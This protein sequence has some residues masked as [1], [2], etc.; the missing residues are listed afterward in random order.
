MSNLK[1][2]II[3]CGYMAQM[4]HIPCLKSNTQ[5]EVTVLCDFREKVTEKLCRK[6]DIPQ[7]TNSVE[8]MLKMDIDAVY[9]LTPVQWH[10]NNI[11][12]CL[13]AGKHVFTEKPAA[14]CVES[15]KKLE[16]IA[17][18]K[19][20]NLMVGYMKRNEA[21]LIELKNIIANNDYGDLLFI[22]NHS[23]I[24]KHWNAAINDLLSVVSSDEI[25]SFD[26]ALLDPGPTWLETERNQDFYSFNNPYY[27]LLDTGCHSI[28]MLRYL[29]GKT[30][31]LMASKSIKGV[32]LAEFDFDGTAGTMEFCLN[33]KM[34]RWDEITELYF[35]KASIKI[36]TPPP[37]D[38]QS[39]AE[40]EIYTEDGN[41]QQ[42]LKLEDNRQWAFRMQTDSFIEKII[43]GDCSSDL[44]DASK[45]IELIEKIYKKEQMI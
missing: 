34:H 15:V 30:P 36:K 13:K 45:D 33:F 21:N 23:F 5:A 44:E 16:N 20:Q 27:A 8:E 19:K 7:R 1:I 39:A 24:G 26:P 6:W 10:L 3:G 14:M 38:M 41:L 22:R 31:E 18:A 12:A 43:S 2:G 37:L 25:P 32:R 4:A 40:V 29:T 28:N 9:V 42:T 17:K 11:K 35:E